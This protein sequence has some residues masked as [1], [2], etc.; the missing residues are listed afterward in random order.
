MG[1][2]GLEGTYRRTME[3]SM[4]T[5]RDNKDMLLSVLEPFLRDPTV[6]WGRNGKAQQKGVRGGGAVGAGLGAPNAGAV[7]ALATITS[8]LNG[9]Y[10]IIHPSQDKI[11]K[12]YA[13]RRQMPP[14]RGLGALKE[15]ALPLSVPGQIQRLIDEAICVYNLAQMYIG[16]QPWN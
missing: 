14:S 12:A 7:A 16:W 10:N 2:T 5:L 11:V 9:V 3:L 4:K 13:A 8:R 1:L 15:E 6:A